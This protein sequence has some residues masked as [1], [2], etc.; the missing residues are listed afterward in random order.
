MRTKLLLIFT[1]AALVF[2]SCS[3]DDETDTIWKDN[4]E[5]AFKKT[6][7]SDGFKTIMSQSKNG[8]IAYKVIKIGRASCRE[9]V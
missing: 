7:A 2:A 6:A 8:S 3:K 4:N 5:A 1:L 9:R